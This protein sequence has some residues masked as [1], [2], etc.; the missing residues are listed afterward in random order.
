VAIQHLTIT[1]NAQCLWEWLGRLHALRVLSSWRVVPPR[2][3]DQQP[4]HG[5]NKC[6]YP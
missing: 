4:E 2:Q 3:D 1:P 6:E 5:V